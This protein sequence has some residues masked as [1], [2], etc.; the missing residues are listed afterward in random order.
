MIAARRAGEAGATLV[1]G[2]LGHGMAPPGCANPTARVYR[3]ARNRSA[4]SCGWLAS[5]PWLERDVLP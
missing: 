1:L 5:R 2:F 4:R 3:P